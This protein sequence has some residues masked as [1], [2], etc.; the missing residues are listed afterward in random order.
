[1][2]VKQRK[3]RFERIELHAEALC[4]SFHKNAIQNLFKILE[5]KGI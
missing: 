5:K 4:L 1:M 3:Q 2:S